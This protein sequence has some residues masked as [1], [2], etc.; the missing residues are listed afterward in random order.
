MTTP[1]VPSVPDTERKV[2]A[3]LTAS[4][5][6]IPLGAN[7]PIY[8]ADDVL[9]YLNDLP[10]SGWSLTSATGAALPWTDAQVVFDDAQTGTVEIIGCRR[11]YTRESF[12]DGGVTARQLNL[13]FRRI[14][15][16]VREIFDRLV[17]ATTIQ[18]ASSDA[19]AAADRAEAARDI[20][21]AAAGP[22]GTTVAPT[23]AALRNLDPALYFYCYTLGYYS[24]GDGGGGASAYY[25]V[26]GAAPGTYFDNG[27][28]TIVPTGGD[29]SKAWLA[30]QPLLRAL[31]W[32]L[33]GD[34]VTDDTARAQVFVSVNRG[35]RL[36]FDSGKSFL[37][38]GV[39]LVGSS[40]DGT[41]L[42]FDGELLLK[43]RTGAGDVNF[44]SLVWVGIGIEDAIVDI[45]GRF[46]GNR[47]NQFDIE[48]TF[49]ICYAGARG[50]RSEYLVMREIS[51]DGVYI[52]TKAITSNSQNSSGL[53]FD[54]IVGENSADSGRNLI[55]LISGD[56][57]TFASIVSRG[58][59]G[60]I[61]GNP[62]PGGF[63]AEA[64]LAYQSIKN[65]VVGS[66]NIVTAGTSGFTL[67]AQAGS[68]GLRNA[69]IGSVSVLNT[70]APNANDEH[71]NPTMS[72]RQTL[73]VRNVINVRIASFN[74][75]FKNAY[76]VG[77]NIGNADRLFLKGSVRHVQYGASLAIEPGDT[78][79]LRNSEIDLDV[80]DVAQLGFV[81]GNVQASVIKGRVSDPKSAYFTARYG[82]FTTG[83]WTQ[84]NVVYSVSCAYEANWTAAYRNDGVTF[85]ETII[86]DAMFGPSWG[87]YASMVTMAIPVFDSPG[88][89]SS[90]LGVPTEGPHVKGQV[91]TN[92][93]PASGQPK[94]WMC[95]VAGTPG[96]WVSTGNL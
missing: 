10:V 17:D 89:T 3:V 95:T 1:P 82:V 23:I 48:Q 41:E 28:S 25:S 22:V 19:E 74:G 18:T 73:V 14:T 37:L 7:F 76:G 69:N 15:A 81:V 91:I 32:G 16:S 46:N 36:V 47:L 50:G 29:G 57:C 79:G 30:P 53:T 2:T 49:V 26:T 51:G 77:I 92:A 27:G 64:D 75:E 83:S 93:S 66:A 86:K 61:N 8:G 67:Y 87:T 33:R 6:P 78:G 55:S 85:L 42:V 31:Q 70:S 62:M 44:Q 5:G 72:T 71:G 12:V 63:D 96:T 68:G 11:P 54:S 45:S 4:V 38:G 90:T 84:G 52:T 35:R 40:Y 9:V 65:L 20:A 58:I 21:V 80:R 24:A 43:P 94:G 56:D 60:I 34:G 39:T 59:G 13:A 88:Y